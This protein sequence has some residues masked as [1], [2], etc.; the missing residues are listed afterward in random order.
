M[1]RRGMRSVRLCGAATAAATAAATVGVGA[2]ATASAAVRISVADVRVPAGSATTALVS[3]FASSTTG[4]VI[5]GFNLPLDYNNDGYV[6]RN[7][8]GVGDLPAGFALDAVPT[9]NAVYADTGFD[10]P[11]PQISLIGADGI[12]TGSG[13]NLTLTA[14]PLK[15]FDLAIDVAATVPAGT[16][17]PLDIFVPAD[18]FGPLFNVA[19]PN[20]PAVIAPQAGTP[21]F[22]SVTVVGVP[23]PTAAAGLAVVAGSVLAWRGRSSRRG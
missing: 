20:D 10:T 1:T 19:G 5:S 2:A 11:Q 3:V 12:P 15:L 17:L 14:T 4:D 13:G 21:V 8:D 16:V 6:D 23:E 22:G 18:P 7:G 9:R